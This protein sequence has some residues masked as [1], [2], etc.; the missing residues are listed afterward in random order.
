MAK[1]TSGR[2]VVEIDPKLKQAL[3]DALGDEGMNLKQWFLNNVGLFLEGRSGS[4]LPLFSSQ[5]L[6]G[7]KR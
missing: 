5:E 3:Y 2:I 7:R 4:T 1:G 6:D